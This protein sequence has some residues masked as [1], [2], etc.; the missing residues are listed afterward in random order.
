[1]IHIVWEFRVRRGMEPEFERRYSSSGAWARLFAQGGGYEGTELMRDA[2]D[3]SR[4]LVIDAWRDAAS[5]AAF[6]QAH[7]AAYST[8]DEECA[9]LTAAEVHIGTFEG[10]G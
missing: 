10:L 5:F 1:L 7:A 8:L 9:T 6:K 4:Y 3:P 2:A